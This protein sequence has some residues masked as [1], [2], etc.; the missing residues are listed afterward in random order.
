V[1]FNRAVL[2]GVVVFVAF[3]FVRWAVTPHYGSKNEQLL[4]HLAQAISRG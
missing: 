1:S 4:G 2:S 3:G